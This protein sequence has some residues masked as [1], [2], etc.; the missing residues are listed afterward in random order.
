MSNN[1]VIKLDFGKLDPN[2]A[3][4]DDGCPMHPKCLECPLPCCI[5]ELDVSDNALH[6]YYTKAKMFPL[7]QQTETAKELAE[8]SGMNIRTAFRMRKDFKAVDGN[9]VKFVGLPGG[10]DVSS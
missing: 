2:G 4:V 1:S 6:G 8:V 3:Y 10:E 9:Y 5:Y 7:I